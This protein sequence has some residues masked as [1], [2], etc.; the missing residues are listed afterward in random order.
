MAVNMKIVN[1]YETPLFLS[2]RLARKKIKKYINQKTANMS[3]EV[4]LFNYNNNWDI[5]DGIVYKLFW[6]YQIKIKELVQV[7]D[8]ANPTWHIKQY[9]NWT[10]MKS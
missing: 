1:L 2:N 10:M 3:H 8:I 6:V 7:L 4:I 9:S 5:Y